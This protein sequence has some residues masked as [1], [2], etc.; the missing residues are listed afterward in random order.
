MKYYKKEE[1][2]FSSHGQRPWVFPAAPYKM[3]TVYVVIETIPQ[4]SFCDCH[5]GIAQDAE[6]IIAIFASEA[7]AAAKVEELQKNDARMVKEFDC[8]PSEYHYEKYEVQQ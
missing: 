5:G 1:S 6:R 4:G 2:G 7:Q 8:D 3:D